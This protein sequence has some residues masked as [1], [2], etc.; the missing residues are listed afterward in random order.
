MTRSM[1]WHRVSSPRTSV[2]HSMLLTTSK[3]EQSSSTHIT[4]QTSPRPS[5]DSN[6]L[7]L[8]KISVSCLPLSEYVLV[9]P[10]VV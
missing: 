2:E 4:R 6:S 9:F 7:G 8:A 3:L 10:R 1:L 5:E